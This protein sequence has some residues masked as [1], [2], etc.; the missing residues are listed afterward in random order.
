VAFKA[1]GKKAVSVFEH[2]AGGHRWQR[3]PPTEKRGRTQTSTITVAVL[4]ETKAKQIH[5][6]PGDLI[7]Q[8]TRGSGPGGQHRNKTSSAV[9]LKH[10][11]TGLKV[12]VD[13]GRSQKSAREVARELLRL[14][15]Q[16]REDHQRN[17]SRR[18]TR[19]EQIGSGMRGDK[20]RTIQVQ[21]DT[22]V[23]H[24]TGKRTNYKKYV[25]GKFKELR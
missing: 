16:Q 18:N 21:N 10:V 1:T 17:Q 20:I 3:V 25:R 22:V 8:F 19:K 4:S 23:D 11:P 24:R 7:E 14:K 6:A 2:E 13:D 15:L 5:L 12:F 9:H